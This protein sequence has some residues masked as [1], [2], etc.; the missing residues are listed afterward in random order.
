MALQLNIGQ[1]NGRT[2][3]KVLSEQHSKAL[4]G[5]RIGDSFK[6]DLV[7]LPGYEFRITGGSDDAG[8][9][10]R[11]D[12]SGAGRKRILVTKG[13]G[14]RAKRKG[15][16]KRRTVAGNTIYSRTVQVNVAVVKEGKA[17][18]EEKPEAGESE[19][20]VE[21][22]EGEGANASSE[23]EKETTGE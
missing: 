8:F 12:V 2:V 13:V 19:G 18:L 7:G 15:L 5:L 21:R 6:G 17:P 20:T 16:R 23:D 22:A 10:M 3:K 4:M 11:W 1:K 9:P 14:F